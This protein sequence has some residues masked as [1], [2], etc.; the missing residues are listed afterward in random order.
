L[1]HLSEEESLILNGILKRRDGVDPFGPKEERIAGVC[2]H[3]CPVPQG[4]KNF[5][6]EKLS[7]SQGL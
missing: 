2:E 6:I 7:A 1:Q 3:V 4:V 5:L